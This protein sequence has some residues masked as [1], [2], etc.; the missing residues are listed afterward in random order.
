MSKVMVV[1]SGGQ[2][3]TTCL[4]W[5]KKHF[6]EVHAITFDYG[7]KH[8]LEIQSAEQVAFI[9][10][11]KSH[12]IVSVPDILKSRSPLVDK[13]ATLETYDN[14]E[15]MDGIIGDRVELTFVPMRNAFF[16]TIAANYALEKDCFDL[17]T[18][19][20]QEDNAN[21]PDCRASFIQSQSDT[22]NQALGI[23]NFTIHT[24]L[25]YLSKADTVKLSKE[26]G[27]FP[28]IAFSHT[29]YAGEFPPCGKCHACVLRAHGFEEA[30]END[31][32]IE[33]ANFLAN[34]DE[35]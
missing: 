5:A 3:S 35:F 9:A 4:F 1:L 21:Y 7:Q 16:L 30:G 31:P 15:Q 10:G 24:P 13:T 14:F 8:S 26:L 28:A 11:V 27:A 34:G 33:R 12:Q 19:V 2:D 29:C 32:L 18:G 17:V 23:E 20:C 6:D 25:M 22:I